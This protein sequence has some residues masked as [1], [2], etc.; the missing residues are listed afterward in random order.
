MDRHR[1]IAYSKNSCGKNCLSLIS[2]VKCVYNIL[3][4]AD[5]KKRDITGIVLSLLVHRYC[6]NVQMLNLYG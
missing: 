6:T 2:A 4:A 1:P 5:F 3:L